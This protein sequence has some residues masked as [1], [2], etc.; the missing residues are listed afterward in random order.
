MFIELKL[1]DIESFDWDKANIKKNEIKHNVFYKECEQVFFDK[2]IYFK[3]EKHSKIEDRFYAIGETKKSRLLIII[4]TKR[5]GKVR[6]ISARNQS[7]KEKKLYDNNI[8]SYLI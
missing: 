4:F 7:K 3:D 2:P 6:V 8:K 5:N 1:R